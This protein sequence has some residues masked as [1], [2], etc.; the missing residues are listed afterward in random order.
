MVQRFSSLATNCDLYQNGLLQ[1]YYLVLTFFCKQTT[2]GNININFHGSNVVHF[3][4][5]E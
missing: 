2:M 4:L 1:Q 3:I 5:F